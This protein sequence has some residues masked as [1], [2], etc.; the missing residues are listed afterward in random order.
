MDKKITVLE[1][2]A[3][4]DDLT[5][6]E[7]RLAQYMENNFPQAAVAN[8]EEISGRN[9]V[10]T[11][12]V[13][14]FAKR[15]G[16]E[17]FRDFS[18][19]LKDEIATNFDLPFQRSA[20]SNEQNLADDP[21]ELLRWHLELGQMN[22]QRT[23]EQVD[24]ASFSAVLDLISNPER[25]LYLMSFATGRLLLHYFYLLAKYHRG[26]I[27]MLDGPDRLVH[28]VIDAHSSSVLLATSFDRHPVPTHSVLRHFHDI[29]GETILITN[30]RSS[31]L[32]KYAKHRLFVHAEAKTIFKSRNAMLVMLEALV[33]GMGTR[34]Q[35]GR[36]P[37]FE[38]MEQ[39]RR[40]MHQIGPDI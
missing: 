19:T 17:N 35:S 29:G 25:K 2:L 33:S 3:K 8:L 15:L 18:R 23:L 20:T 28:D 32:L 4:L 30:R 7:R 6:S 12:T 34:L 40:D 5:P 27:C 24:A 14:R 16:F 38:G 39:L 21:A 26:N 13:T 1:R 10:S 22:L 31:P 11:A 36:G 9:A 37:R